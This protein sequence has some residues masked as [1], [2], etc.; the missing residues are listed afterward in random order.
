MIS[1][2]NR[3]RGFLLLLAAYN[4][5]W[6]VFIY[7]FD[8]SY[9]KWITMGATEYNVWVK[10]QGFGVIL[11]GISMLM[12]AIAPNK[13][14]LL[15][16]IG[17]ISKIAGGPLVYYLIMQAEYNKRF[18]FHLIMNDLIWVVPL[19]YINYLLFVAAQPTQEERV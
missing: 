13:F 10:G 2:D 5:I 1:L 14:K 11:V 7:N 17:F 3:H 9:V 19:A 16:L 12:G 6:G 4:I 8:T 18:L 15:I